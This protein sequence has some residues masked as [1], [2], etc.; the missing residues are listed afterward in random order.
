MSQDTFPVDLLNPPD[1]HF[2]T[3]DLAG[4]ILTLLGAVGMAG[5]MGWLVKRR[6]AW[7]VPAA[8][9]LSAMAGIVRLFRNPSRTNPA[10]AGLVVAPC[11]GEIRGIAVTQEARYLKGVARQVTIQV[12][13]G[14]VQVLRAPVEG[15][16]RFRRYETRGRS[17]SP[18][19]T[20]WIGVRHHSGARVLVRLRASAFWRVMPAFAGRRITALVDLD[21]AAQQGQVV[22]HLPL[23][24]E[25]QVCV[26]ATA[27]IAVTRGARVRAGETV[28]ARL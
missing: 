11:D 16:V 17:E 21:D 1:S 23:G 7:L 14:D 6:A 4:G 18:D 25:V 19:D 13:L 20:L 27:Q 8:V 9:S 24:G 15:T 5:F 10:G 28:L 2:T 22:G 26:P 12:R 3:V